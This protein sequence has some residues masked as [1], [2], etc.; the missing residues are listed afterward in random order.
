MQPEQIVYMALD[1]AVDR[2]N[3]RRASGGF[4]STSSRPGPKSTPWFTPPALFD[5]PGH[6]GLEIRRFTT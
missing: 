4:T 6:H 2:R 5:H 3:A 1:G